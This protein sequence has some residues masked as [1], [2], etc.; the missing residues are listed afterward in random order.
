M[1]LR[2]EQILTD[3]G[4]PDAFQVVFSGNVS[5]KATVYSPGESAMT[6]IQDAVDAEFPAVGNVYGDRLGRLAVHGRYA[7]FDPLGTE[8]ITAGWDFHDWKA[9]D[10]E[11]VAAD[12]SDTAHIRGFSMSPRRGQGDQP[13]AGD[14]DRDRRRRHRG[15]GRRGRDL[16]AAV[17]DPA[18]VGGEPDHQAGRHRVEHGARGVPALRPATSRTTTPTRQPG[19]L[20]HLPLDEPEHDRRRGQLAAPL[21]VRHQRPGRGHD[22]LTR[23]RRLRRDAVLRR[24]R[25]RDLPAR[26]PRAGRR[27]ADARPV[28]GQLLRRQPLQPEPT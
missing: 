20:D 25:A 24:G 19:H 9:G 21:R 10:G 22:R 18:L 1:Q 16:E 12:P 11:A 2:V 8:A 26:R 23:R 28:A 13:R 5:L 6:A 15:P 4:I 7:R 3:G 14:A 17:R 27:D